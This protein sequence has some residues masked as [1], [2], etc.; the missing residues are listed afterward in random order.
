MSTVP[1]RINTRLFNLACSAGALAARTPAAQIECWAMLGRVLEGA[2]SHDSL[3]SVMQSTEIND[4]DKL[5]AA[6]NTPEGKARALAEI[7]GHKS[8]N[9]DSD[10]KDLSVIRKTPM[11]KVRAFNECEM[12]RSRHEAC[13]H[14]Q[15]KVTLNPIRVPRPTLRKSKSVIERPKL[16]ALL[17]ARGEAVKP[18]IEERSGDSISSEQAA[19]RLKVSAETI[20]TRVKNGELIGYRDFSKRGRI[21]LPEWQFAGPA[22]VHDWVCQVIKAYGSNGWAL[23]DFIT[24]PRRGLVA[25][26]DFRGNSLLQSLQS[27]GAQLVL[28]AVHRANPA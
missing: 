3:V 13:T 9:Y 4:L 24:K 12:I 19:V 26:V 22:K 14:A 7:L 20:R 5:F 11:K 27:G 16:V 25:D 18:L 1:L 10:P 2:L 17:N 8:P 15:D 6:F 23:I 28:E 21:R